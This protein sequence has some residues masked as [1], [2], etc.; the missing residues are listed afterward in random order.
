M[1]MKYKYPAEIKG[2]RKVYSLFNGVKDP[3]GVISGNHAIAGDS[4]HLKASLTNKYF[5]FSQDKELVE[6]ILKQNH[7]NYFKS[8]IQSVTLGKYLGNGLLTNNGK[9]WL[10]QRR[11]IQPGFSKV[12]ITNLVSIMEDEIDKAFQSFNH[13]TDI[14]LYG[15]FHTLAFN[16]VAKTLFS[17][18]IDEEKVKELGK[19]ITEIQEVFAKEV[20]IPLYTQALNILG[21]TDKNIRKSKK[22]KHIIQSVLDKRRNSGE[23]KNDLLDMLIHA[24]YE[25]T[26]LPMSDEQLVD[27]MLILFI[28]GHETTANALTF[29]FFEISQHPEAEKKLK[30]EIAQEGENVFSPES[31]MK[32]SFT[33]NII[34]EAM[35]LHPPAWAIDRQA[36]ED[37]GFKEYSWK[38]GTLIILYIAGLHR[39]PKYWKQPDSFIPE[40]FDDENAKNF[41]Y[42]PFGAGPRLCIGEHFA[43][44]EMALIIRKFY[45]NYTFI[46]YQKELQKK[47]LVTLRAVSLHGKIIK[48][49]D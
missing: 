9:D 35:R 36:L 27:E 49:R 44:M 45:N 8:E 41:A 29:I 23:E 24:K 43:I 4:Y 42:Y 20:R 6:Y 25:D 1:A 33:M 40:R 48:N 39:N 34:K 26:Q 19:I 16:I 7:K 31:L 3:L 2:N 10:K 38:K 28:A 15:F 17:S 32:K 5:I 12:K 46:S 22:A 21:I 13:E 14:D 18:D 11:L 37:D 30:Q 47:A